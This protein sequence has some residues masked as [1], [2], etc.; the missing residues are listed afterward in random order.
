MVLIDKCLK[1]AT[2]PKSLVYKEE[3]ELRG[4]NYTSFPSRK[5]A[6]IWNCYGISNAENVESG[7]EGL[8][9]GRVTPKI[10][11]TFHPSQFVKHDDENDWLFDLK[12]DSSS[13][14]VGVTG[15]R[16]SS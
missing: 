15:A 12:A 10:Y 6:V 16:G 7:R 2:T 13:R 9:H 1:N 11:P 8:Y 14:P 5:V 4:R 3:D